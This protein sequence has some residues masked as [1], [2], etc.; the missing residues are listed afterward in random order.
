MKGSEWLDGTNVL[1]LD[2]PNIVATAII[3]DKTAKEDWT[4]FSIPFVFREGKTVDPEKL[5]NGKYSLTVLFTSSKDGDYFSGAIGS[6]L[7][8]DGISIVCQ[9]K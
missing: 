4:A 7:M 5:R 8:V 6:T 9:D 3:D 2:N 1:S